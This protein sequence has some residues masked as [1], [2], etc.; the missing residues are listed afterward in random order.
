MVRLKSLSVSHLPGELEA[1]LKVA[2]GVEFPEGKSVKKIKARRKEALLLHCT[3]QNYNTAQHCAVHGAYAVAV[4]V[5]WGKDVLF[6]RIFPFSLSPDAQ[7]E[8]R[9]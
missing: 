1:L 5:F 2:F 4:N 7:P 6:S 9:R 8:R 3:V